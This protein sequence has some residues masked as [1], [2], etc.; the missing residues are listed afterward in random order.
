MKQPPESGSDRFRLC[1]PTTPPAGTG[2]YG[3]G[4][5]AYLKAGAE[6]LEKMASNEPV[7][8]FAV[9]VSRVRSFLRGGASQGVGGT[10][11]SRAT[12]VTVVSFRNPFR[13]RGGLPFEPALAMDGTL[14][15]SAPRDEL[16]RAR[17]AGGA[18]GPNSADGPH[19]VRVAPPPAEERDSRDQGDHSENHEKDGEGRPEGDSEIVGGRELIP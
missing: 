15:L 7:G 8:G 12:E 9:K 14:V 19:L 3:T 1:V 16:P 2:A 13:V 18:D 11:R 6:V 5:L 10:T 17:R 4:A